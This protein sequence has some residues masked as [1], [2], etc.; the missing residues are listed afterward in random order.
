[1]TPAS[2]I[3]QQMTL[4]AVEQLGLALAAVPHL[5][6][7]KRRHSILGDAALDA[8]TA[9]RRIGLEILLEHAPQ[10]GQRVAQRRLCGVLGGVLGHP[11]LDAIDL[12]QQLR[13]SVGALRVVVPID[14][15]SGLQA[16]RRR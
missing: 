2:T 6:I 11:R 9:G 14:V 10:R 1:M 8:R 16:W 13:E 5:R 12:A 7:S 15:E 3:T 4:V